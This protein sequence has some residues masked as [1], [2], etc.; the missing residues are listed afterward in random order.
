[1]TTDN[2]MSVIIF[3]YVMNFMNISNIMEITNVWDE[4]FYDS[5]LWVIRL[6]YDWK[7]HNNQNK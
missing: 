1:M 6:S 7:G 3:I 4:G 2:V 5:M